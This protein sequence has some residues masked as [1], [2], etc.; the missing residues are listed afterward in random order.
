MEVKILGSGCAKCNLLERK[1]REVIESNQLQ[2]V[3]VEKVT[4]L[5]KMMDYG[6]MMTPGLIINDVAKS[7]GNIPRDDQ[8]LTWLKGG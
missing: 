4:D 7:T 8:I 5:N 2:D 3:T 1:V 6:I